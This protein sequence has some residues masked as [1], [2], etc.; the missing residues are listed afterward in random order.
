MK[1]Q[2]AS[3]RH[4]QG[5]RGRRRAWRSGWEEPWQEM[6]CDRV[7]RGAAGQVWSEQASGQRLQAGEKEE[8]PAK[9]SRAMVRQ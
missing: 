1:P 6:A 4:G 3:G 7:F 5:E 8:N 9:R 2:Q